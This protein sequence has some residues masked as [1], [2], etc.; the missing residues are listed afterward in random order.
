MC[1][2]GKSLL[3]IFDPDTVMLGKMTSRAVGEGRG[4]KQAVRVVVGAVN[5]AEQVAG[6]GFFFLQSYIAFRVVANISHFN[7]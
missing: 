2:S 7:S 3:I 1:S 6:L 4:C 5:T